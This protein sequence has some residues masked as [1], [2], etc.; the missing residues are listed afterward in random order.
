MIA[1][2]ASCH[3]ELPFGREMG[4]HVFNEMVAARCPGF[5]A[6]EILRVTEK[7]VIASGRYR[8]VPAI[9]KV[10]TTNNVEWRTWSVREAEFYLAARD[11]FLSVQLPILLFASG[12]RLAIVISDVGLPPTSSSR[13]FP[14]SMTGAHV[15]RLVEMFEKLSV[16][17]NVS[18]LS[19][20]L[21]AREIA[22]KISAYVERG[23][24][25]DDAHELFHT[26]VSLVDSE[27]EFSHGDPVA[28]NVLVDALGG[29]DVFLIDWE[30]AG[31]KLACFDL[32]VLWVM[33]A[34]AAFARAALSEHVCSLRH[35]R[36]RTFVACLV[37]LYGRETG[38][39]TRAET[40][41]G[42]RRVAQCRSAL[43]QLIAS[44]GT[45]NEVNSSS[46]AAFAR[47]LS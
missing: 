14:P 17:R 24:L 40:L 11:G 31:Y 6:S 32:A 8:G 41:E 27:V 3:V 22:N 38:L 12:D 33:S 36:L 37:Y 43:D 18:L 44:T 2:Q 35:D 15:H 26:V 30:H 20:E 19:G 4:T 9:A 46:M 10:S 42:Q 21:G 13:Y 1:S 28:S 7:G 29:S 5:S 47:R 39:Q 23:Y 45:G 16:W 25:S 34:D